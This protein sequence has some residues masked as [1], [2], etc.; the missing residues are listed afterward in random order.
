[1]WN[2]NRTTDK[3]PGALLTFAQL[4]HPQQGPSEKIIKFKR[5]SPKE[6]E[7]QLKGQEHAVKLD[8]QEII[9]S[10]LFK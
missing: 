3:K 9:A 7:M 10:A 5:L 2:V 1:M 6:T 4:C 8:L